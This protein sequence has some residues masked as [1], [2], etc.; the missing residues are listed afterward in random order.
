MPALGRDRPPRRQRS[1]GL[2]GHAVCTSQAQA[3][4]GR[5][6][7]PPPTASP[8]ALPPNSW[9]DVIR[10]TQESGLGAWVNLP[11]SATVS[12][13]VNQTDYAYNMASLF[14]NGNAFTGNA[15]VGAAPIY[16][17]HSNEVW[18]F[19]FGQ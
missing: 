2:L 11:V 19:G 9:E 15:G 14:K 12:L 1:Q 3:R 13:P 4:P 10:I 8:F 16:L 7:H 18:N 17:E 5:R 6:A